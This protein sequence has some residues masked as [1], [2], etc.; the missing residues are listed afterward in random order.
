MGIT[1]ENLIVKYG[2]KFALKNANF[3]VNDGE[4]VT[5]I[6]PNGSGKTTLIKAITRCV[7]IDA[8]KILLN[9]EEVIII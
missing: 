9:N 8:G 6:G 7:K 2:E 5:I 1:T 3:T 4:V